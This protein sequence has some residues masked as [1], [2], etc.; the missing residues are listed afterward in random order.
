[1][2]EVI[3]DTETTGLDT[4]EGHR[5]IEIGAV[6]MENKVPTG[7]KYQQYINPQRQISQGAYRVHGIS[8]DFLQDRPLFSEI[9]DDFL[10]FIKDSTLVIHNAIFDM[11]FLNYEL[12]LMKR[13]SIDHMHV[14]D[15]LT[16]ARKK[17]PGQR[18]SLDALCRRF[19]VDNSLRGYHGALLDAKLLAEVYVELCGGRQATFSMKQD[20]SMVKLDHKT[21]SNNKT[22]IIKPNNKEIEAHNTMIK[23]ISNK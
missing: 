6:E 5:I 16:M 2:R 12:S 19:K 13:P 23:K 18:A 14:V 8:H 15:T 11:K 17:Y 4:S 9:A 21:T 7:R 22:P 1:M 10:D 3:L 20:S